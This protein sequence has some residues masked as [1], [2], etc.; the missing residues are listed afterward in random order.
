MRKVRW[1]ALIVLMFVGCGSDPRSAPVH[2]F[3]QLNSGVLQPSCANFTVCHSTQGASLANR[4]NFSVDPYA[5]L[6]N[7]PAVNMKAM[8]EG[9]LLVKPCDPDN[10]FMW[11]KLTLA[12]DSS[13]YAARM[14]QNSSRL[15]QAQLDGIRAWIARGALRDEPPDVTGSTCMQ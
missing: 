14:P 6:V 2:N 15:P 7:Q 4:L 11:I 3:D 8:T 13:Q 5:A 10:S 1:C 12:N 9:K